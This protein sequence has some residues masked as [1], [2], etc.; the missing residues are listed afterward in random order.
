MSQL[1]FLVLLA[2]ALGVIA[3]A[4]W[5]TSERV[6]HRDPDFGAPVLPGLAASVD[7]VTAIRLVGAGEQ[8]Q[9]S[10]RRVADHWIVDGIG[11]GADGLRI[12]QLLVALG[13]LHVLEPKTRDP[14][15]YTTLGVEDVGTPGA[16]SLRVE[17]GGL[18]EPVA[19]LLGRPAGSQSSY[20]RV[21]GAVEALEARPAL[22]LSRDPRQWL[23]RSI[24][25]VVPAR[26]RSIEFAPAEGRPWSALRRTRRT[27]HVEVL[28][29]PLGAEVAS[30]GAADG[31]V[32]LLREV[33]FDDVR[34]SGAGEPAP[35]A[36]TTV[37][38]FDG[39]VVDLGGHVD[40]SGHWIEVTAR[41][42]RTAAAQDL[43]GVGDAAP[44]PEATLAEAT[45]IAKT[46][47]GW[48]YQIPADR[49]EAIFLTIDP[50]LLRH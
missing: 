46:A 1:R 32:G 30:R 47:A 35:T 50:L 5:L 7:A 12:R 24:L 16:Q 9:V 20:V 17:L 38:C 19:L 21:P 39:L 4:Y 48:S 44:G 6:T 29:L 15:R 28:G 33:D 13:A 23:A 42:D 37:R 43:P 49:Y 40:G 22:A 27:A 34:A 10:L 45:R 2:L 14:A 11:Y 3:G 18:A 36:R 25:N 31:V 41:V 8:T 26:I